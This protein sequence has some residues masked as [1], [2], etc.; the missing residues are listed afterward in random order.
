LTFDNEEKVG[1]MDTCF[2]WITKKLHW[3]QSAIFQII[4]RNGNHL[5]VWSTQKHSFI[6]GIYGALYYS[7]EFIIR[8]GLIRS[9][10]IELYWIQTDWQTKVMSRT[11]SRKKCS[12][13]R[14]LLGKHWSR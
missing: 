11:T 7:K 5:F 2:L 9:H 3:H 12:T 8:L 6:L 4:T 14:Q 1:Y 13:S 10:R